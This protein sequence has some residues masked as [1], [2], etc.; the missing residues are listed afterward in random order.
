VQ[1]DARVVELIVGSTAVSSLPPPA[2]TQPAVERPSAGNSG[3]VSQA[4]Q[5]PKLA[6]PVQ[7]NPLPPPS[8]SF[9]GA[10]VIQQVNPSIPTDL[11]SMIT[12]DLQI[13]VAVTIDARGRVT[14]ARV[15]SAKGA[16][17]RLITDEVL[18]AARMFRF[19]PAQDN[20]RSVESQVVLTFRFGRTNQ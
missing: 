7:S 3:P 20:N 2:R 18:R 14:D 19:R 15:T 9:I 10:Q 17:A 1:K 5:V 12:A 8:T 13:D 11:R 6:T 4:A 16:I